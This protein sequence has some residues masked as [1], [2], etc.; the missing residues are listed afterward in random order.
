MKQRIGGILAAFFI[1][2]MVNCTQ[3]KQTGDARIRG[4]KA[5]LYDVQRNINRMEAELDNKTG[6]TKAVKEANAVL[7][8]AVE[9]DKRELREI[10]EKLNSFVSSSGR[11]MEDFLAEVELSADS[12]ANRAGRAIDGFEE[13]LEE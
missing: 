4:I 6:A 12:L 7:K 8:R 2:L 13:R 3:P 5:K 11:A 1:V 10:Q 9:S